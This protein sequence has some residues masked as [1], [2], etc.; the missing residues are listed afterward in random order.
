MSEAVFV[1]GVCVLL[2]V[3]VVDVK[4]RRIP[5]VLVAALAGVAILSLGA[6]PEI[7]ALS[8]IT[9]VLA[10]GAPLLVIAVV[11]E[12]AFGGGDVKL[13]A[14]AGL[15]LGWQGALTA[16]LL[17][18]TAGGVYGAVL[19]AFRRLNRQGR[20]KDHFAFGPFLAAGIIIA[21]LHV[22]IYEEE[23]TWNL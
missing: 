15:L 16:G 17:A 9:G 23:H 12:G 4:T 6:W 10:A 5:D 11:R 13:M 18:L 7:G 8:R 19:S 22:M 14:A 21:M 1:A 2:A 3:A 20:G